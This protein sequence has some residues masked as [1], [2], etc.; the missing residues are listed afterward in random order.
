[1]EGDETRHSGR[2]LKGQDPDDR[3]LR[4]DAAHSDPEIREHPRNSHV[5]GHNNSREK[6]KSKTEKHDQLAVARLFGLL[7]PITATGIGFGGVSVGIY[8]GEGRRRHADR[9]FREPSLLGIRGYPTA[10]GSPQTKL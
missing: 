7:L 9:H 6:H 3:S 4:V 1:M 5:A 2:G 10:E 8:E